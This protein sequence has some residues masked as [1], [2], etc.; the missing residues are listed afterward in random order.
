MVSTKDPLK[1]QY[2][3]KSQGAVAEVLDFVTILGILMISFSLIG[4]V[5]YPAFRNAQEAKYI[6]NTKQSF[7]VLADNF[8]KVAIGQAPSHGGVIKMYGG[9]LSVNGSSTITI[10]ATIYNSTTH[11]PEEITMEDHTEMRSIEN[12]IGDT[13][14][15]YEGTGVW[16]KYPTGYVL[17]IYRPLITN[18]SDMLIIPVMYFNGFSSTSGT[19]ISRIAVCQQEKPSPEG[20]CGMPRITHLSNVS[21]VKVIVTGDYISGWR[22]YFNNTMKWSNSTDG[23]YTASLDSA[24]NLDVYILKST[25]LTGI[26]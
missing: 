20:G 22:D 13:V 17:N 18:R 26:T 15:A 23:T 4:L 24:T 1:I 5:G 21:K 7:V 14:V 2:L 25:L 10:N 11:S 12:S 8:N 6:E 9:R 3:L 16:V 19:G